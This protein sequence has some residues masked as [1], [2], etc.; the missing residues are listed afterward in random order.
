MDAHGRERLSIE[1]ALARA[2][3]RSEFM[4]HFQPK[5]QASS[6]NVAGMEALVRWHNPQNGLMQPGQF[7][8]IAEETGMIVPIGHRVLTEACR[9][10]RS[11]PSAGHCN[12][13]V[14]GN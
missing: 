3:E 10:G 14:A 6:R 5:M 4:L 12:L 13:R 2:L 8:A 7:I 1:S 9:Q 11:L